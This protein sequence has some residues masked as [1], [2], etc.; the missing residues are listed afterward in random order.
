ML[1]ASIFRRGGLKRPAGQTEAECLSAEEELHAKLQ[2]LAA[3]WAAPRTAY[4]VDRL[5]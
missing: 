3:V 5:N 2:E 1:T 4:V